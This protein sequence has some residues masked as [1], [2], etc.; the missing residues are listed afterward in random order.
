MS[1]LNEIKWVNY[2][3]QRPGYEN[4]SNY[5]YLE[6]YIQAPVWHQAINGGQIAF[7]T[8]PSSQDNFVVA[9]NAPANMTSTG[10]T[11]LT[12]TTGQD[13]TFG[14]VPIPF[15]FYF[16]G[17][18]YRNTGTAPAY[19]WNTNNVIGFG[20]GRGDI[21]WSATN[22]G[23]LIGNTDRRTN[24]YYYSG[25]LTSGSTSYMNTLLWAQN[26]YNDGVPD[27]IQYQLRFFRSPNYQYIELRINT[28]GATQGTW[29][30]TNGVSYQNTFGAYT[31]TAGTSWV[32]RSDLNGSNWTFSNNY[33]INLP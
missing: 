14:Y 15:D 2:D 25:L 31:A 17:S 8:A 10:M 3:T 5:I 28:F 12:A 6:K 32:L 20:T 9:G 19:Y 21:S 1:K 4:T 11:I 16:Y 23:I 26:I 7:N 33:Y 30:L 24:A 18:N 22:P 29:N 13:D 27:R